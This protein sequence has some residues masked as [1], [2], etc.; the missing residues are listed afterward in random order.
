MIYCGK[1][2]FGQISRSFS[3]NSGAIRLKR[4]NNL[5]QIGFPSL[6]SAKSDRLL[7]VRLSDAVEIERVRVKNSPGGF[8]AE[9]IG[10]QLEIP[11]G[12]RPRRTGRG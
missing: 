7:A 1:A 12:I 10:D 2:E 6:R 3:L 9:Y 5:T 8:L 4:P 11:V